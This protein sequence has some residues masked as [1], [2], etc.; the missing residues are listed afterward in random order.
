[1]K[2]VFAGTF[3]PPTNGHL[4]IIERASKMFESVDVLIALNTEKKF[5]FSVE[6]RVDMLRCLIEKFGNVSVHTFSGL[7]ANYA[8][9]NGIDVLVRGVRNAEDCAYEFDMSFFNRIINPC[10]DTIFMPT[11]QKYLIVKSSY[12]KQ[13]ASFGGDISGMVPPLV[14]KKLFEKFKNQT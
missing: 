5:L 12:I 13:L 10:I 14:E 2:A 9:E 8:K 7:V 6:E 3:D 11:A 4:D 1:M